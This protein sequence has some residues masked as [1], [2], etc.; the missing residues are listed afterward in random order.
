MDGQ[1]SP[2]GIRRRLA[3]GGQEPKRQEGRGNP[4][5]T[6]EAPRREIRPEDRRPHHR[7]DPRGGLCPAPGIPGRTSPRPS[8]RLRTGEEPQEEQ[9]RGRSQGGGGVR[10]DRQGSPERNGVRG[11]REATGLDA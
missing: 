9:S 6:E 5:G 7:V 11:P 2:V 1:E 4:K 3:D 10:A 8:R